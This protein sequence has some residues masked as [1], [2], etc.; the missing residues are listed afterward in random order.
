MVKIKK[1]SATAVV[2]YSTFKN[3]YEKLGW[4]IRA[5]KKSSK[6]VQGEAADIEKTADENSDEGY[7]ENYDDIELAAMNVTQLRNFAAQNDIDVSSA[8]S[9][10]EMRA[11]IEE[12]LNE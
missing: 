6:A 11:I 12:A 5:G 3:H 1:G 10:K 7:D 2:P 8:N 4:K 9:K